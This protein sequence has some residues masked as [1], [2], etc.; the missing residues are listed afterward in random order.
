[1]VSAAGLA[2]LTLLA[3]CGFQMRGVTPLPFDTL[4][5]GVSDTTKFGADLRRALRAASPG[6]RLVDSPKDAQVLLQQVSSQRLIDDTA[7]NAQGRVE[8]YELSVYFTFRVID[9]KGNAILGDTAFSAFRELPYN[10][11]AA[12]ALSSQIDSLYAS[13]EQSLINRVLRRLNAIDVRENYARLQRGEVN[14]DRPVFDPT[15]VAPVPAMPPGW[16]SPTNN[17]GG[18]PR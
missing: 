18:P 16:N 2:L 9:A 7:L 11:Q 5:V 12:Q 1:M 3:A 17:L 10:D 6:T 14:P 8:E 15:K 13:M 4:Y